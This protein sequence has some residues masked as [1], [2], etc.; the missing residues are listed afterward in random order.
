MTAGLA[1]L[2]Y[3]VVD[4]NDAGWT[5]AQ[6]LGLGA[7]SLALI[8]SFVAIES[9]AKRPLLP[10]RTFSNRMLRSAN[11]GALL[12]TTALF[13]MWFLLTLYTQ[14][15]LGY[16][17]LEAGLAQLPIAVLIVLSAGPTQQ[18]VTRIGPRDPAGGRAGSDRRRAAVVLAGVGRRLVP[19][20]H[21]GAVDP[22]R[23]GRLAR[24]HRRHDRRD[25]RRG[26]ATTP[27]WPP[28]CST[29]RSRSAARSAWR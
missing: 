29:R 10:L 20:R 14:Q 3:A 21:P 1:P 23:R 18:L 15:V 11:V 9:R 27:G 16:T 6:T 13:P 19:R 12:T 26:R 25:H 28:G 5:S 17:P 2:I 4:A 8:A 22:G 24:L 7:L